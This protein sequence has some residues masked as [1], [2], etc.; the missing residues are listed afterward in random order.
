MPVIRL[1]SFDPTTVAIAIVAAEARFGAGNFR[2]EFACEELSRAIRVIREYSREY[3]VPV[4][5]SAASQII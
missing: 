2:I 3:E 1:Q 5:A 4:E